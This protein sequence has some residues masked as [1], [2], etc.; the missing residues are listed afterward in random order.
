VFWIL[1][2]TGIV[3]LLVL[4]L[5]Y[6]RRQDRSA[7]VTLERFA[8]LY[9]ERCDPTAWS[10]SEAD[11]R[12]K[13]Y[14]DSPQLERAVASQLTALENGASCDTVWRALRD[15]DFPIPTPPARQ[16]RVEP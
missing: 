15:A 1:S 10:E 2:L 16:V 7:I 4:Y 12:R 14:L 5:G 11:V 3:A 8:A 6:E 9:G 13:S